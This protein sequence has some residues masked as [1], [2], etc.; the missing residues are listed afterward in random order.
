MRCFLVI[1]RTIVCLALFFIG[2]AFVG[3]S[4]E[5]VKPVLTGVD[6]VVLL[7][8]FMVG[9][10]ATVRW[11]LELEFWANSEPVDDE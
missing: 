5:L 10:A 8:G 7:G 9:L 4:N 11:L 6:R 1:T 2:F 3:H